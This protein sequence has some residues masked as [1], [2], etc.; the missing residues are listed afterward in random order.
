MSAAAPREEED[1]NTKL[2]EA[3]A[4]EI[5]NSQTKVSHHRHRLRHCRR[6]A[7]VCLVVLVLQVLPKY[8]Q[9]N[10]IENRV[11]DHFQKSDG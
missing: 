11:A 1:G 9:K 4:T 6:Q 7:V 10:L 2:E 8:L 3:A 5:Q